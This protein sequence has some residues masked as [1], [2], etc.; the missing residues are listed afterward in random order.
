MDTT[1]RRARILVRTLVGPLGL[2]ALPGAVALSGDTAEAQG[3]PFKPGLI[4]RLGLG[5]GIGGTTV[6]DE[7][8]TSEGVI[9]TAGLGI[10]AMGTRWL[11]EAEGQPFRVENPVRDEA[12]RAVYVLASFQAGLLGL[13]VRPGVGLAALFFTGD[14]VA[15]D[16]EMGVALGVSGGYEIPLTGIAIE[17]I[18]RW[19]LAIEELDA[20]LYGLQLVKSWT[21]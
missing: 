7:S 20:R 2:F 18:A 15:V 21:F 13:Y 17:A 4:F 8:N 9:G 10:A 5:G 16:N 1:A 6:A 11:V 19:S 14:D 12:F 3:V